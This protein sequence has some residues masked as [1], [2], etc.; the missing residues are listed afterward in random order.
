MYLSAVGYTADPA[1]K[2]PGRDRHD[3]T[4]AAVRAR[5]DGQI[6]NGSRFTLDGVDGHGYVE[7]GLGVHARYRP[8]ET[9][10]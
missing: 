3:V 2:A 4:D 1:G 9:D 7:T 5:L 6:D 8:E 10:G